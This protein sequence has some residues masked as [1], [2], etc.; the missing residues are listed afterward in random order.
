MEQLNQ[1]AKSA[2]QAGTSMITLLITSNLPNTMSLLK[3]EATN[4]ANIKSRV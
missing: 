3:K 4:A 2:N 1:L